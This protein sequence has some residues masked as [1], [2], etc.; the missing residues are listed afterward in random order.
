ML[1][2]DGTFLVVVSP[3]ADCYIL[4]AVAFVLVFHIAHL[5]F[6]VTLVYAWFSG[7]SSPLDYLLGIADWAH[8]LIWLDLLDV[9]VA[10]LT[11]I[12]SDVLRFA[13]QAFGG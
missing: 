12:L 5:L 6:T 8:C 9:I 7:L 4:T 2:V 11:E 10:S 13:H 1:V 3:I